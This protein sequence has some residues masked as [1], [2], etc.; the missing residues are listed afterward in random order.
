M[1]SGTTTQQIV[2]VVTP[3]AGESVTEG[4]ILEWHVKVGDT[5]KASDTIVEISTDKVD[6]ELPSPATGTVTELLVSEGDT[7]TVGQVI[8]R[9]AVGDAEAGNGAP[10]A[11]APAATADGAEGSGA[12]ATTDASAG[13]EGSANG[14]SGQIVDVITPA[15][16]ESVTE[17]TILEWHVK[18][19]DT[20]K[21]SDTIVEISTDKVDVELPSPATGTVTE[22]LVSEG[23]TV[24]VGQVI[25][26]IAV[27]DAEGANG[28]AT[29]GAPAAASDG[30]ASDAAAPSGQTT[31][32]AAAAPANGIT[33]VAAR[34]AAVEGVDPAQ[35]AGSG[36]AGRIVKGDVLA[37]ATS[38][39]NGSASS[40]TAQPQQERKPMRG[41]AAMLV[42]YMEESRSV[43]T[44]TSFRTLP[45]TVLAARRAELKAA[46]RKVSFTHL[47]A[48]ALV[49]AAEAMPVMTDHFAEL[50][51]KPHRISDGSVNLGLA[52]DVEKKDG[53]RTLMVP[54][55]GDAAGLSFAEFL[56]AY[57]ALVEKART[58]AL[59]A[60]DLQGA[61]VTL[62]NPGG[63]GTVASVPR[64]MAG[65]GTIVATGSIA[66]PVGLGH[67]GKAISAEQVM[68]MTSTYD[69]RVIQGAESGRFLGQIEERLQG[70]HG[71]YEE[72]F[73][74]LGI[75]LGPQPQPPTAQVQVASQAV[76]QA[77]APIDERLLQAV[78]AASTLLARV[79]SH[80]HLAAHLDPLG[81]E[82]EGDPQL[83]P[84]AAGL[85]DALMARIPTR[86]LS[87]YAPGETFAD[88]LPHLREIYCGTI[89]YEVEHIASHRQRTWLREQIESGAYRSP[90]DSAEREAMLK[91]LI[92][93]DA[94][95]RFMHKAYLGQHQFSIEGLDMTVPMIDELIKL[96]ATN[97]AEEVVIGMAHRGRLNVLAHN[98]GRAYDT[99]FAE[100]EGASTLEVV[101]T[102]PQGGTGDVKYHHGEQGSFKLADGS[103]IR[104]NLESNP[105]H[106][107][108]VSAVVEGATR[109]SQTN[110]KGPHAQQNTNAAVPIVIHGDA[111]FPGQGIV[112]ETLNLQAL[113]GYKVGGTVH[114]IMN[115]QIGFTTDPDDARSTRW[116]SDL[117][118]GFDVPIIHVNADDVEACISAVRLA[119]AFRQEFGHDV[120]ID[121]IG[122]RRFGHNESDEPAYT[123][124]EMYV[125][126][127]AKKRVF[128]V[129][130]QQ[131]IEGSSVTQEQVDELG[132]EVW[133]NLT[134]LHQRLKT[135]ITEAAEHGAPTQGTGEY[136]LD[137]SPSPEVDTAIA[138][139][140]LRKL[141]EDLLRVP[142]GFTV[143]RKLVKQLERRREALNGTGPVESRPLD[144]AH[145]EALA[146]ASLLTEGVP[147]R[148]TGQDTERGTFSQ[149]HMVLHDEKT[150]LTYCPMQSLPEALAPLELH[151]SPLSE[152]ACLGF[153]YGYSQEAPETLVLWEAQY[154]DFV[155]SAQVIIDQFIVSAL[156]KWGQTSRLTLL[157]P[158]G[159]E[160][161][162]PE[163]SSARMERFL[164][165]AA[166]GNIRVAD[167]TTP[168]QYFH[169][170]RRQAKIAKQRPLIVMTPKSLLRLPQATSSLEELSGQSAFQPVLAEQV[171]DE[172]KVK[173]LVLCTGKIYYDLAGH[174][175]R[176]EATE[177]A[178]GRIEL[179]YPFPEREVLDLIGRYP[180][181]QEIV[182]VQEEPRN[183]GA[184]A[185]MFPRLMQIM[186]EHIG[187]GYIGRPER[188]SPGE[189]YPVA[190]IAEQN[191]IV[192]TAVDLGI[193][194][195]QY[196]RKTPGE[197]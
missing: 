118:K 177:L 47:I 33:P 172:N 7:V 173:R 82:P 77:L 187:F 189:G 65:Q 25:A 144:W 93:V 104:V 39:A 50:D 147:I 10:P 108:Y 168:A 145:A 169:L 87:T 140:R 117:A 63:L 95:E 100:F 18:V 44:A 157:L 190:H 55:I 38:Q 156:A 54:V 75:P 143:H 122:Y 19:G 180:N 14:A 194:I 17:G 99:I 131:L 69:H 139:E 123:Q 67:V 52:V 171:A 148:L 89:A 60:D 132:Q 57:D 70:E 35:I 165:L 16:G 181:L 193:P 116:A 68:T 111:S 174:A 4:T 34:A 53:S 146:F 43:P 29:K 138:A 21:A 78:N 184:R 31:G 134:L 107:E 40:A 83:D 175:S 170:L 48:Y 80:G 56:A 28:N 109:A 5:I 88:A 8:A 46:G 84:E 92:E 102:I 154:G 162:G 91:R 159:Y 41:A 196:P 90:L 58:G 24:T 186:P 71:F 160:G 125:K 152:L 167:P 96:S 192:S 64:L 85:T 151:N 197:R 136:Q 73:A 183:M 103:T 114:L 101:T 23:D 59:Q 11:S 182:W 37:A 135:R 158:H 142:D 20:I 127:K 128:E 32:T 72:V 6:V 178:I 161:S 22:L 176:P 163:H 113:D 15:A 36:P 185:H 149:R 155:N 49:R 97:H 9:I 153:E 62:T 119:F 120:L 51:G 94:L 74:A 121:L 188:A 1:A 2:D 126:I 42:R 30:A 130:A 141:G 79:R 66:Y 115:N 124:P 12:G 133:D 191:R 129:W 81:S 112:A 195:S 27:G 137:R 150:G 3:A 105:S 179:L 86:I 13:K 164:M 26:R 166:E 61:N 110:R 98:L 76:A 45:V 106:L